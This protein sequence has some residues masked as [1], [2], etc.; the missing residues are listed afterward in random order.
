MLR[1]TYDNYPGGN[2]DERCGLLY[3]DKLLTNYRVR[4]TYRF[5]A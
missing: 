3:Y 2:F 1:V 4:I 5:G